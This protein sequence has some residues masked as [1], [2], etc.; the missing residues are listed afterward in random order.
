MLHV[1]AEFITRVI[2]SYRGDEVERI[3]PRQIVKATE[4]ERMMTSFKRNSRIIDNSFQQ[5]LQEDSG[6]NNG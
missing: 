6:Q 4:G 1:A 3:I 5:R 2:D